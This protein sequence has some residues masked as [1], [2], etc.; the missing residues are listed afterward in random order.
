MQVLF[1]IFS[2]GGG[3]ES[4]KTIAKSKIFLEYLRGDITSFYSYIRYKIAGG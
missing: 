3:K 1:S 2:G 4:L